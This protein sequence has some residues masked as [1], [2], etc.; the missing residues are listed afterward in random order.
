MPEF[1]L[2]VQHEA[3]LHA[4]P[5]ALFVKTANEY[6]A[7][8]EVTNLTRGEGPA[9]GKSPLTLLTLAVTQ[10]SEILVKAHG[11]QENEALEALLQLVE[12]NFEEE[13]T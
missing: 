8:I 2:T 10:G 4:R 6:D 13:N 3:G 5:L 9:N 1:R 12:S 11:P 7:E